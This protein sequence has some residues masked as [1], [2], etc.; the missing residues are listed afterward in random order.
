MAGGGGGGVPLGARGGG[1][2]RHGTRNHIYLVQGDKCFA[3][4]QYDAGTRQA[5][6]CLSQEFQPTHILKL[7]AN[8]AKHCDK[9]ES[10][11][12]KHHESSP[13]SSEGLKACLFMFVTRV[14]LSVELERQMSCNFKNDVSEI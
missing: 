8:P 14:K 6:S 9:R 2:Y 11:F 5:L 13:I 7:I 4:V 3:Y 12:T 1:G 10:Y